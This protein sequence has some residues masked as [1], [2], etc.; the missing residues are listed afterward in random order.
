MLHIKLKAVT[1]EET[2]ERILFACRPPPPPPPTV[3]MGSIDKMSNFS[4]HGHIAHQI[5]WDHEIQ[6]HGSK[7]FW[8]HTSPSPY[9]P[10]GMG[11][12]GQNSKQNIFRTWSRCI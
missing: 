8:P 1:N 4:E 6:Q 10:R 2:R 12:K 9:D 3:E 11:S 7:S 5:K